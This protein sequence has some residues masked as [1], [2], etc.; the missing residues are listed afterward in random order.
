MNKHEWRAMWRD[1]RTDVR[2]FRE[3]HGGLPDMSRL[4]SHRGRDMVARRFMVDGRDGRPVAVSFVST[5]T[6]ESTGRRYAARRLLAAALF[7]GDPALRREARREI[8]A[9]REARRPLPIN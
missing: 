8:A 7:R 1:L 6:P 2:A 3:I 9:A 5:F 4:F